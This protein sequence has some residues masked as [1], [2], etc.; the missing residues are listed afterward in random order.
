[1][2]PF[3]LTRYS[4]FYSQRLNVL[5]HFQAVQRACTTIMILLQSNPRP[6]PTEIQIYWVAYT[7]ESQLLA[8]FELPASGLGRYEDMIPFPF[9]E[10]RNAEEPRELHR[11]TFLAHLALRKLLNRIHLN[12]YGHGNR[13]SQ[14]SMGLTASS[15][16][17]TGFSASMSIIEELDHQLELW[18]QHLPT[19][20][21]FPA[22]AQMDP[23]Q[24]ED[25]TRRRAAS[26]FER[27]T[28]AL[29]AR[30]CAAK[31]IILRPF[32]YTLLNSPP[33]GGIPARDQENAQLCML[34]V[35]QAVLRQG[36]LRDSIRAIPMPVNLIRCFFA[37][38]IVIRLVY[39]RPDLHSLLPADWKVIYDIQDRV[40]T[41][42]A[43]LSP[44]IAED[45]QILRRLDYM[46]HSSAV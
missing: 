46:H 1:M 22:L 4:L 2:L 20:L 11:V 7:H 27:A 12:I 23:W 28:G 37:G 33:D 6:S 43:H 17:S 34:A 38:A 26:P 39:K 21:A 35:L 36:I 45:M 31:S 9:S 29:R 8:E 32:L 15:S 16:L 3:F 10:Y 40:E 5:E 19:E 41:D 14:S 18:R 44:T 25:L 42:A 13:H 24:H 30:Y